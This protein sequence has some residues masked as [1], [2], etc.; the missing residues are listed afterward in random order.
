M[1]KGDPSPSLSLH[2]T[3]CSSNCSDKTEFQ[4]TTWYLQ[5]KSPERSC[6]FVLMWRRYCIF[7]AHWVRYQ[8]LWK[9]P[10]R[11]SQRYSVA[12]SWSYELFRLISFPFTARTSWYASSAGT[13]SSFNLWLPVWCI[14]FVFVLFIYSGT[15]GSLP[16]Q[17]RII[18]QEQQWYVFQIHSDIMHPCFAAL[19]GTFTNYP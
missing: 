19:M 7:R 6:A 4:T 1:R 11:Y 2:E 13:I 5:T 12:S 14:F 8:A 10:N 3:A 18:Q 9:W 16:S 15:H 17:L